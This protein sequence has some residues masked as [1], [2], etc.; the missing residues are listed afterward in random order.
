MKVSLTVHLIVLSDILLAALTALF[1]LYWRYMRLNSILSLFQQRQTWIIIMKCMF[2]LALIILQISEI[3][4][5]TLII[6][7]DAWYLIQDLHI[8]L[9]L[10]QFSENMT[11]ASCWSSSLLLSYLCNNLEDTS[12]FIWLHHIK[13]LLSFL[14]LKLVQD[15]SSFQHSSWKIL[16]WHWSL[17]LN[18]FY[19]LEI[20][21]FN[22]IRL[23]SL[24]QLKCADRNRSLHNEMLHFWTVFNAS[25]LNFTLFN[26]IYELILI[27]I[28]KTARDAFILDN[29][30]RRSDVSESFICCFADA[31]LALVILKARWKLLWI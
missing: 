4:N 5:A 27:N 1:L 24:I 25:F 10:I 26:V 20:S 13:C 31:L 23:L 30:R 16:T 15:S 14:V 8:S 28:N 21:T 29:W 6:S 11:W 9:Q 3:L 22:K 18:Y 2:D 7:N 17:C 19:S 12:S